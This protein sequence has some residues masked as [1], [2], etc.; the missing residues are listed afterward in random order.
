[1]SRD[2]D[3]L[4][5][6]E[7]AHPSREIR[8]ARPSRRARRRSRRPGAKP[9]SRLSP[10]TQSK[11]TI[12]KLLRVETTPPSYARW[13]R[14]KG[15]WACIQAEPELEWML[16]IRHPAAVAKWLRTQK[17]SF[18]WLPSHHACTATIRQAEDNPADSYTPNQASDPQGVNTVASLN[19]AT[20]PG[21]R[22]DNTTVR[23]GLEQN[24]I[25]NPRCLMR[26]GVP[27]TA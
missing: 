1:M 21:E 4:R 25:A 17:L 11:R 3:K 26:G 18:T 10:A 24:G 7:R 27:T 15:Q 2:W 19:N 9:H 14:T 6:Q 12:E 23:G 22:V 5:R 13:K 16:R 8:Y 20:R